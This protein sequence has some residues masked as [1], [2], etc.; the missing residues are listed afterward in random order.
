MV[1]IF[2]TFISGRSVALALL[3]MLTLTAMIAVSKLLLRIDELGQPSLQI[4]NN[5]CFLL[6]PVCA[7][8][9]WAMGFYRQDAQ[10]SYKSGILAAVCAAALAATFGTVGI[11]GFRFLLDFDDLSVFRWAVIPTALC[12][13]IVCAI[14]SRSTRTG[15]F[16]IFKRHILLLGD[17]PRAAAVEGLARRANANIAVKKHVSLVHPGAP[18]TTSPLSSLSADE[19]L[20]EGIREVVVATEEQRGLPMQLL[21]QCKLGGIRITDY[22]TFCE[23]ESGLVD[24][25]AL[26]PSWLVYSEGCRRGR[27]G[28]LLKRAFDILFSIALLVFSGPLMLIIAILIALESRGPILYTQERVG[29]G[30][31]VFTLLKFRSMRTDAEA[32]AAA[33]WA[34]KRDPRITRVGALLRPMR[35]DELPQLLNVLRGDMSLIGPRPERP[36]FVDQLSRDI[37]FYGFRHVVKPGLT[38]W[39]QINA[40]YAASIAETRTKLSY[41]LYY[42]KNRNF[43]LDLYIALST[44]RVVLLR[45]GAV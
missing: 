36:F 25:D 43:F 12:V 42:I 4:L 41:D 27:C 19:L 37:S 31:R 13:F 15:Q 22:L 33:Q 30:G 20:Q 21:L 18:G 45:E 16:A 2:G 11:V 6:A 5:A 26:Q 39:A 34:T 10:L 8:A 32:T 9:I 35:L 7:V 44:I 14:R 17:G 24:L 3:D 40:P 23:R 29:V 28:E 1:K 38:G